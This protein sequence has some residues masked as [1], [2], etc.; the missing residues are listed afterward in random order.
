MQIPIFERIAGTTIKLTWVNSGVTPTDIR[1]GLYDRNETL[2]SSIT[3]VASGN[4]HYFAPLYV[5]NTA[6]WYVARAI[7]VVDANTYVAK[8]FVKA[9]TLEVE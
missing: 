6:G 7:A 2:V 1:M 5:P 3:P 4:G 9:Y 8:G